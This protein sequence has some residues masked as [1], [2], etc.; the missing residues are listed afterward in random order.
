MDKS[1]YLLEKKSQVYFIQKRH[2]SKIKEIDTKMYKS[3]YQW[4]AG[5]I[6][7]AGIIKMN[8]KNKNDSDKI[9]LDIEVFRPSYNTLT[10]IWSKF[11]GSI[12]QISLIDK[13]K[14][15]SWSKADILKYKSNPD[16]ENFELKKNYSRYTI[17]CFTINWFS[18]EANKLM[19]APYYSAHLWRYRL[20]N[21]KEIQN[22]FNN[23]YPLVRSTYINRNL[24]K[25]DL[26]KESAFLSIVENKD[27]F[28]T[29]WFL[30][31][32]DAC[33]IVSFNK[34]DLFIAINDV[35][36]GLL[37]I[38]RSEFGNIGNIFNIRYYLRNNIW[39]E[40]GS[41]VIS[42]PN[43]IMIFIN[44][45][46][47]QNIIFGFWTKEKLNLIEEY[48]RLSSL[49][50]KNSYKDNYESDEIKKLVVEWNK[51]FKFY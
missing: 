39:E 36:N 50:K 27:I 31:L 34:L 15:R 12:K 41:W 42:K 22:I 44:Y 19:Y 17:P 9:V 14:V 37:C 6:D 48:C 32:F 38:L 23:I 24:I 33:G 28:Y 40:R 20:K 10:S 51:S 21:N 3:F 5:L 11:G 13:K 47:R 46:K 29:Y 16:L 1:V 2:Y 45:I 26:V 18:N 43:E 25:Y 30:G 7:G 35:D 49:R 4:L 8:K